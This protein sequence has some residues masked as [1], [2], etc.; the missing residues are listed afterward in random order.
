M[1]HIFISYSRRDAAFADQLLSRLQ[2]AGFEVWM[3][4]ILPVGM[5]WRQEIDQ[6]IRQAFVVLVVVSPESKASE[7]VTYEWAYALGSGIMVI[8]LVVEP[9]MLHP[10]LESVQHLDFSDPAHESSAWQRLMDGLNTIHQE[11]ERPTDPKK[12]TLERS[13][14][15]GTAQIDAPGVWLSVQRGS[16]QG[17]EWNLNKDFI[18]LGRDISNDIVIND[19]QISRRHVEFVRGENNLTFIL[20]DLGSSNGTFVN[21]EKLTGERALHHG[22]MIRLGERVTLDYQIIAVIDGRR[23]PIT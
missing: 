2:E 11:A 12:V 8:P 9:T 4:S 17:Q 23:I 14:A 3:D 22:D 5:D 21:E 19:Q 18:T 16:Q 6:A 1:S 20:R 15:L 10:R 7:Y 13:S